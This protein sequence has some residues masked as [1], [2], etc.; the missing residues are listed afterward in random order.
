MIST[1]DIQLVILSS[2]GPTVAL[3]MWAEQFEHRREWPG[4]PTPEGIPVERDRI[5]AWW[6]SGPAKAGL[7][8]LLMIDDDMVPIAKTTQL[9]ESERDIVSARC[10]TK[11]G[12]PAHEHHQ[13]T[14][15]AFKIS[16]KAAK[17]MGAPWFAA[18]A[19][20]DRTSCECLR[21]W[22][23]AAHVGLRPTQAGIIGHRFPVTVFPGKTILFGDEPETPALL[24]QRLASVRIGA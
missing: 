4:C 5:V 3:A 21:F 16:R 10:V 6:L 13:F 1:D 11:N 8:W 18:V 20:G 15:A 14:A 24:E 7:T 2:R 17:L 23:R 12:H 22:N 9:V 19:A